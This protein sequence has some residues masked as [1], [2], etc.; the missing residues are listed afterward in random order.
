MYRGI[1]KE[2]TRQG[3]IR[4]F[5]G[6]DPVWGNCR[7]FFDPDLD[8]YDWL[9]VY[10]DLPSN[11]GPGTEATVESLA[12]HRQNT[13]HVTHEPSSITT[14][15]HAYQAQYGHVL[16]S[17]EPS[18]VRHPNR[19]YSNPGF[20]WYYGRSFS[21]KPFLCYDQ[22]ASEKPKP[23]TKLIS[24]VCS[25]KKQKHT[26]HQL[27]HEFTQKIK[28]AIPELD[29]FGHG[30]RPIDD[31]AESLD[32]YKYHIAIENHFAPHHWTEKLSD[33]FLGYCMPIYAGANNAS[34]YVPKDSFIPIEL[35]NVDA[36]INTI[37][38]VLRADP[39]EQRLAAICEARTRMLNDHNLFSILSRN[40][41][42]LHQ[43]LSPCGEKI[44]CRKAFWKAHP[45]A[46]VQSVIEKSLRLFRGRN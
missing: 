36:A 38:K 45:F 34:E 5:P 33:P 3:W 26:V 46:R 1:Y 8:K 28:V 35:Q 6:S 37:Q 25:S 17:Q 29:I 14:Y 13:I 16:T 19:I 32:D 10:H 31:K 42:K 20:P 30:V 27:R 11:R 4:Q 43:P 2:E 9:V 40:I 7:Y 39:Y 44:L 18:C 21:G 24:T 15:G 23:K 12:C 41:E 22:I